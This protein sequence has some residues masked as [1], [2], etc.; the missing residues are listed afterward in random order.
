MPDFQIIIGDA[1]TALQVMPAESVDCCITS[2]PYWGLR[3]YGHA[4]QMGLEPT[5][6]EYVAAMVALFREVSRVLV[7]QG[8]LWSTLG[9]PFAP[10]PQVRAT[11][12]NPREAQPTPRN[13]PT[14]APRRRPGSSQKTWWVSLGAW[15]L[16]SRLMGGISGRTSSGT[17]PTRCRRA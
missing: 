8:T 12:P 2:P 10:R 3:D 5:P 16:P 11:L 4:G 14:S 9:I 6:G 13:G 1:L 7:P 15:P 17:S